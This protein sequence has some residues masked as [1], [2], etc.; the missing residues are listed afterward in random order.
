MDRLTRIVVGTAALGSA[1]VALGAVRWL[2]RHPQPRVGR[3]GNDV[4]YASWGSGTKTLLWLQ[5]GPGSDVPR[6]LAGRLMGSQFRPFIADGYKVF[7][8]TRRRHMPRGHSISDMADDVAHVIQEE[9]GTVDVV[10]GLSYGSLIAQ[11]LAANHADK[12]GKVVLALSGVR[13]SEWGTDVDRRWTE[14]RAAG[15]LD[16]AGAALLE[17]LIPQAGWAAVRRQLGRIVG[18]L[19]HSESTP[20][21]DLLVEVQAEVG[22]DSTDALAR[23]HLPVLLIVA[24]EDPFFPADIS[25]ETERLIAGCTVVRYPDKGHVGAALSG[26]IPSDVLAWLKVNV[27][28]DTRF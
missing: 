21:D 22:F 27:A 19:S 12:V 26:R 18:P 5:G 4:E 6:G 20:A 25:A 2:G 28:A 15:R 9:F 7:S 3:F 1:A 11:Y 16:E 14:A 23:I 13:I 10:V 8:L 17:Y 24:E